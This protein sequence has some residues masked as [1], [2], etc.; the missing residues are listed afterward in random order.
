MKCKACKYWFDRP[1]H[2]VMGDCLK[3][4]QEELTADVGCVGKLEMDGKTVVIPDGILTGENFGCI[5]FESIGVS[6]EEIE[7]VVYDTKSKT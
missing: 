1:E 5:H 2:E 6:D 4:S 3:I 7:K